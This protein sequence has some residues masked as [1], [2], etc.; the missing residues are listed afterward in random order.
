MQGMP[1][2]LLVYGLLVALLTLPGLVPIR[3]WAIL[4]PAFFASFLGAGLSSWWLALLPALT[5]ALVVLGG[6]ASWAGWV[7]LSLVVVAIAALAYEAMLARKA[8][9]EFDRVLA[10]RVQTRARSRRRPRSLLL[11]FSMRDA[12]VE[13]T[14]NVRY[15]E[16]AGHRHLLDVYRARVPGTPPSPVIFQIHGGGWTVGTK[17]TQARPLMNHF[18]R[19]GWV[20]VAANYRLSPKARWP[21]HLVDCKAA[22][23]WIREHV[24]EYGGDPNRVVVTGG[25]A[26]GH[27]TAMMA[28]TQNDPAYQP[29]FAD[30][31]TSVTAAI[32]MYGVYDLVETFTAFRSRL[33]RKIAGWMGALV[34]G[35][36]PDKDPGAYVDASLM[37]HTG[38]REVHDTP[39]LVVHGTIDN[40]VPVEQARRFT[41]RLREAGGDVTYVELAGAPHAFDV[42]HST[43]EHASTTGIEWWLSAVVPTTV[44]DTTV[45]GPVTAGRSDGP[46]ARSSADEPATSDPTTMARTAPS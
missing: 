40:L 16:G 39:F 30:V 15:A 27:L 8:A 29:G 45:P 26:G 2:V 10:E 28:L 1:V 11:P 13:R 18:A 37:S 43:W 31:D 38:G 6:L 12:D 44:P 3:S 23:A 20:C 46:S 34:L 19:A 35:V 14:K 33:G 4:L 36:T 9:L 21:D 5:V 22:L 17:N 24:H 7:G 42:F 41:T 25:S 32:P